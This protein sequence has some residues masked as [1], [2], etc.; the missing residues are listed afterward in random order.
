M[1][2]SV[3]SGRYSWMGVLSR[4]PNVT[5]H[6]MRC[7][8]SPA[9]GCPQCADSIPAAVHCVSVASLLPAE[10][11]LLG[12]QLTETIDPDRITPKLVT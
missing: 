3:C 7:N 12:K 2:K 4:S 1:V 5:G 10:S 6:R 11:W 8:T 9:S